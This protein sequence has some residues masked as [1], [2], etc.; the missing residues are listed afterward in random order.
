MSNQKKPLWQRIYLWFIQRS[1]KRGIY[2]I[3]GPELLPQPLE[4]EA[5]AAVIRDL[6]SGGEARETARRLLGR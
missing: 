6:E 4:R 2:Y 3:H 1:R 5:E